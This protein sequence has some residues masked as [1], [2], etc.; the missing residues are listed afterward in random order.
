MFDSFLLYC[1][2]FIYFFYLVGI[3]RQGR[4]DEY[5]CII[6]DF[7][8]NILNSS[9]FDIMLATGLFHITFIILRYVLSIPTF[10][11]IFITV[12]C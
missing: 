1:Y 10:S 2:P 12:A 6:S 8:E 3:A 4:V 7:R 9:P 11:R 5:P